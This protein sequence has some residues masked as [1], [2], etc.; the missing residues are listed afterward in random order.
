[1]KCFYS[2]DVS[3]TATSEENTSFDLFW[4]LKYD[5]SLCPAYVYA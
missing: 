3:L 4:S 2:K 1:M 5:V